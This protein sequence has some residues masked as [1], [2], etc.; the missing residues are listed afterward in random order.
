LIKPD[1]PGRYVAAVNFAAAH[2]ADAPPGNLA[3]SL[4]PLKA[5][6]NDTT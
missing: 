4:E 2:C 3:K 5:A 6:G 1:Y